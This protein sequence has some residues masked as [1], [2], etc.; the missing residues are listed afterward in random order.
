MFDSAAE[1]KKNTKYEIR[2]IIPGP[3]S[4][5]GIDGVSSVVCS[6]VTFTYTDN[7]DSSNGTNS[8]QFPEI[9]FFV[10]PQ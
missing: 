6:G 2:A 1:C 7:A 9:L 5:K 10:L 3:S 4:W 8:G